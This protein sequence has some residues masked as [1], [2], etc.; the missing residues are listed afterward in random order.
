MERSALTACKHC[1]AFG[2]DC[3]CK[4]GLTHD[5]MRALLLCFPLASIVWGGIFY[6]ASRL[7][8]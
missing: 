1:W 4:P 3:C 8:R 7:V 5:F 6:A 2:E